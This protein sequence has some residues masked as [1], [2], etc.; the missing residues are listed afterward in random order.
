MEEVDFEKL[1]AELEFMTDAQLE[2]LGFSIW[3]TQRER[4]E[5]DAIAS[6]STGGVEF[7]SYEQIRGE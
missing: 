6:A 5:K 2:T 1:L 3:V 4:Y 7:T